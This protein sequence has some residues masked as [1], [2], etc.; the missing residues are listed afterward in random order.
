MARPI[1]QFDTTKDRLFGELRHLA[2]LGVCFATTGY[3]GRRL[4]RCER[5]IYRYLRALQAENKIEILTSKLVRDVRTGSP[6]RKRVIRV[7]A[8]LGAVARVGPRFV[9]DSESYTEVEEVAPESRPDA[10]NE[11]IDALARIHA[12]EADRELALQ[13]LGSQDPDREAIDT[14]FQQLMSEYA[15]ME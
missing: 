15:D 1:G 4:N 8:H 5:Q 2:G 6:Y 13:T 11:V 10:D 3:L 7:T 14:I 9:F 12:A